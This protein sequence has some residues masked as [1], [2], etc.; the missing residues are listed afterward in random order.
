MADKKFTLQFDA[1]MELSN[2]VGQLKVLQGQLEK[3]ELPKDATKN[4][5]KAFDKIGRD[6]AEFEI[7]AARGISS[8]ADTKNVEKAWK[9]ITKDL[10][11]IGATLGSL[12]GSKIFPK[13][14]LQNIEKANGA[15]D[16]YLAKL[17][18]TKKSQEYTSKVGVRDK[19]SD[20]QRV[21]QESLNKATQERTKKEANYVAKKRNSK[22]NGKLS[23]S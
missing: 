16:K 1:K 22:E 18:S 14:V 21:L 23:M 9:Q 15:L 2:I 8:L 12:D 3:M 4:F 19:A 7:V 11:G 6:I 10:D 13:E 20:K 5:E 17:E